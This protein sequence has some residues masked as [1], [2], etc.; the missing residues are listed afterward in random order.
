MHVGEKVSIAKIEEECDELGLASPEG[1]TKL[2]AALAHFGN[3]LVE[4]QLVS[5]K[6][7]AGISIKDI[8]FPA[9]IKVSN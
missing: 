5:L 3:Q 1:L 6:R 7:P 4:N 9:S 8:E 2:R